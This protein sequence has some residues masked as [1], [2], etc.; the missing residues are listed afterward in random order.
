MKLLF[1]DVKKA[2]LNARCDKDDVG[3]TARRIQ[4]TFCQVEEV[5]YGMRKAAQGVSD[6]NMGGRAAPTTT[7]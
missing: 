1:V 2:H 5:L 3:R 7:R 4:S 6:G